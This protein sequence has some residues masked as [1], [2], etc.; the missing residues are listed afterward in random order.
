MNDLL[1]YFNVDKNTS[2]KLQQ[3]RDSILFV[4][5]K[6]WGSIISVY[7]FNYLERTKY[8]YYEEEYIRNLFPQQSEIN[9]YMCIKGLITFEPTF[10][11]MRIFGL[12]ENERLV[13][14]DRIFIGPS[15]EIRGENN[16]SYFQFDVGR[17][18]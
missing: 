17:I 11:E 13:I 6:L 14:L 1:N 3:L 18:I 15:K 9:G 4:N 2:Q 12:D 16:L 8:Y 5:G 7:Y 10:D